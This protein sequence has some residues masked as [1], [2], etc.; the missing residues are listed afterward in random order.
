[1]KI[2]IFVSNTLPE[3]TNKYYS[4]VLLLGEYTVTEGYSALAVPYMGYVGQWMYGTNAEAKDIQGL[5]HLLQYIESE[6]L[7]H[8]VYDTDKFREELDKGLFF[9]S[10]IPAGYGLGS[11][12]ALVAAFYD[13]FAINKSEDIVELKTILAQTESVFHGSSSGIDPTVSY[14]HSA[15]KVDN[16]NIIS[17]MKLN[18]ADFGFYLLDTGL[19]RK[20][21]PLVQIFK[22]KMVV[23][24]DFKKNIDL[25]GKANQ[26]AIFLMLQYDKP[27]LTKEIKMISSIEFEHFKEM[28]PE[29][30]MDLW[31][32]GLES[33]DFYIKLC[34][35]GGGGMML[36]YI[37]QETKS[38]EL[39]I[40]YK[41]KKVE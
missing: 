37:P 39:F 19:E 34:G 15:I 16:G 10:D 8:S 30:I 23:D 35:A 38:D 14:L 21:A 6:K 33:D 4:K 40:A 32:Q 11:S 18:I 31:Q 27:A 17:S 1:M 3:I 25:L 22:D 29:H 13:R 12:G 26:N 5:K 24:P 9:D 41:L 2:P 7:L 20:T 28:I 36:C